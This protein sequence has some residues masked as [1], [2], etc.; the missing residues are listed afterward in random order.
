MIS[1]PALSL[2]QM[3]DSAARGMW[4]LRARAAL[5]ALVLAS[6]HS[7]AQPALAEPL[8]TISGGPDAAGQPIDI[9]YDL[10]ALQAMPKTNFVTT[11]MWT[12]GEQTF[13]GVALYALLQTLN[14]TS[15]KVIA[16]AINDYKIE[17]PLA[18][19]TPEAPIIAYLR[20]G[21]EMTVRNKGPLWIVYPYDS[22]PQYQSEVVFSR[23]IW[24]LNR[25]EIAP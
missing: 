18:E 14:V 10:P 16:S 24:Q 25:I 1:F 20:N 23:S 15:G 17:I 5:A 13:E 11:T 8:L 12:E 3:K 2:T 21:E 9:S 7:F 6:L 4:A 19:I 22:D